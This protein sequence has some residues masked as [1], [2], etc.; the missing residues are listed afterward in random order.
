MNKIK[1]DLVKIRIPL[2]DNERDTN[3]PRFVSNSILVGSPEIEFEGRI[4]E[5]ASNRKAKK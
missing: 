1:T 2:H 5:P 4:S 3:L